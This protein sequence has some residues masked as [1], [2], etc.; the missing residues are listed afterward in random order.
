MGMKNFSF[1]NTLFSYLYFW[2]WYGRV[3]GSE[4][5]VL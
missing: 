1:I 2:F 3:R 4:R 5:G